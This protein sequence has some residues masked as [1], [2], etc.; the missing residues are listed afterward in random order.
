[1]STER[2]VLE[3]VINPGDRPNTSFVFHGKGDYVNVKGGAPIAGDV[4]VTTVQKPCTAF[5]RKGSDLYAKIQISLK[6]SL[7][8]FTATVKHLDDR[9]IEIAVPRGKVTTP[10]TVV[11]VKGE[12]IPRN[13]GTLFVTIGVEFPAR[14]SDSS[15]EML[16]VLPE[17]N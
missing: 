11:T 10:G 3:P 14:F 16:D 17:L 6:E 7:A 2:I 9:M 15:I 1:M 4:V 13:K 8:G 12:G 5:T